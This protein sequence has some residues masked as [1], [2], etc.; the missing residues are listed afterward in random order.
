[1]IGTTSE[2]VAEHVR[3]AAGLRAGTLQLVTP[4]KV[5]VAALPGRIGRVR[6]QKSP[7][8]CGHSRGGSPQASP[9][10][11][12]PEQVLE[13][14]AICR[15]CPKSL[16]WRGA[17]WCGRPWIVAG[18]QKIL[19]AGV[20]LLNN[21]AGTAFAVPAV[22][23]GCGCNVTLKARYI[24]VTCDDGKWPTLRDELPVARSR[25]TNRARVVV[26]A[27]WRQDVS[28][29]P[30]AISVV[31][32]HLNEG[33]EP[34]E[35]IGSLL[36]TC[37]DVPIEILAVD[38]GSPAPARM[39]DHPAVRQ[40]R[41]ER[42]LGLFASKNIGV[43]MAQADRILI[44]DAHMRF[45]PGWLPNMVTA[46]D[47]DHKSIVCTA[48]CGAGSGRGSSGT[49]YA[50]R[51]R[52]S[53]LEPRWE[54]RRGSGIYDVGCLLGAC[55]GLRRAWWERIG[56]LG[57]LAGWGGQE[58]C[59]SLRTWLAG[60]R[61]RLHSEIVVGHL[62]RKR[63]PYSIGAD[64]WANKMRLAKVVLPRDVGERIVAEMGKAHGDAAATI[65]REAGELA[66]ERAYFDAVRVDGGWEDYI[67]RFGEGT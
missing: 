67:R 26:R 21:I 4:R 34:Y 23:D 14:V 12:S 8:C 39:P 55:Y 25:R 47:D 64:R 35:T 41:N 16:E 27:G 63:P 29:G 53:D 65:T 49:Y 31:M 15:G 33:N 6:K 51:L 54:S 57:S 5:V 36:A 56:G 48:C 3:L 11:C 37:G 38:D 1:M 2:I 61:C 9:V 17:L 58:A 7:G 19:A 60:G 28:G 18:K 32:A 24:S 10:H 59:L 45:R 22:P 20:R 62:F 42:R 66:V 44:I 43:A 13:R 40:L 46:I 50:G 52:I 30:P